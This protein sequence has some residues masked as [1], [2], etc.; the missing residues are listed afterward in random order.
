MPPSP[1]LTIRNTSAT[2]VHV[3]SHFDLNAFSAM[4]FNTHLD[5]IHYLWDVSRL[6]NNVPSTEDF[7]PEL[8]FANRLDEKLTLIEV[9]SENPEYFFIQHHIGEWD[10]AGHGNLSGWRLSEIPSQM[11]ARE[12]MTDYQTC[13]S[14]A[15]P[16]FSVI[17]QEFSGIARCYSRLLL[18]IADQAGRISKIILA[19]RYIDHPVAVYRDSNSS[20][21][22]DRS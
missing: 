1:L 14:I 18:P 10:W 15:A 17:E 3:R 9:S 13:K 22:N 7:Q 2:E 19:H 21:A 11:H 16:M 4:E 6:D 12:C 20:Y 5:S 8:L